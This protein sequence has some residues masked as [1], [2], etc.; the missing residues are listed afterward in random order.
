MESKINI[1]DWFNEYIFSEA[2]Q[3][4]A[5]HADC[6]GVDAVEFEI[7]ETQKE[8]EAEYSEF[9]KSN[10]GTVDAVYAA[11][12]KAVKHA[13]LFRTIFFVCA[14][15]EVVSVVIRKT[16]YSRMCDFLILCILS[17]IVFA[18]TKAKANRKERTYCSLRNRLQMETREIVSKYLSVAN[19]LYQKTD[20]LYLNSLDPVVRDLL[21]HNR[22]LKLSNR[23][24]QELID[25]LRRE[26]HDQAKRHEAELKDLTSSHEAALRDVKRSQ[27]DGNRTM[28]ELLRIEQ[29]R[30]WRRGH[31]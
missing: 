11:Y 29:E 17:G 27:D 18:I 30:E 26:L 2:I 16:V 14:A 31:Y 25:E 20:N 4:S 23:K 9:V 15:L 24:N 12:E 6:A 21:L 5:E 8:Y 10:R 3:Y 19:R 7:Y 1:A 13:K 22:E 28:K